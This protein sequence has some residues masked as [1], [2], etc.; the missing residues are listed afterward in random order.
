[1]NG[2]IKQ[3]ILKLIQAKK[4]C[5]ITTTNMKKMTL[6]VREYINDTV[7]IFN[8]N[9]GTTDIL[10]E[11]KDT[12][13]ILDEY[14]IL[15]KFHNNSYIAFYVY[16]DKFS[17]YD[18]WKWNLDFKDRIELY[19]VTKLY[20]DTKK[21]TQLI[22]IDNDK[23]MLKTPIGIKSIIN[24]VLTIHQDCDGN[25][26][27]LVAKINDEKLILEILNIA[28]KMI[29]MYADAQNEFTEILVKLKEEHYREVLNAVWE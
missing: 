13:T 15:K 14:V 28:T 24:E 11:F 22:E 7:R 4:A 3:Q 21:H 26:K 10:Q 18:S 2:K 5:K 8:A 19:S 27:S 20:K 6:N 29:E 9:N 1:M 12:E 23:H 17:S 16:E 25:F